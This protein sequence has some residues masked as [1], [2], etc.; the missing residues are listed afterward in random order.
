MRILLIH[1]EEIWYKTHKPAVKN[2]PD[3]PGEYH[4]TNAVVAYVSIEKGD[5]DEVVKNAAEEIYRY[6]TDTVK[7]DSIILYPYAHLSSTLER[8]SRAHSLLVKLELELKKKWSKKLHRAPFGWYKEFKLHAKGHPLSELSR[9]ITPTTLGVFYRSEGK[10]YALSEAAKNNLVPHCLAKASLRLNKLGREKLDLFGVVGW[11]KWLAY[12]MVNR[13]LK[14]ITS[15]YGLAE[16]FIGGPFIDPNNIDRLER[17]AELYRT[18]FTSKSNTLVGSPTPSSVYKF[19]GDMREFLAEVNSGFEKHV[20]TLKLCGDEPCL[21]IG[22]EGELILY[23]NGDGCLPLGIVKGSESIIGPLGNLLVSIIDIESRRAEEGD[24]IPS[25]PVWMHPITVYII[26]V[27]EVGDYVNTLA[28]ELAA[29]GAGVV[30][31]TSMK[32][33]GGRVRNAGKHWVPYTL[34]I[35]KREVETGTVTV[36]RRWKPGSQEAVSL[37]EFVSEVRGVLA[38]YGMNGFIRHLS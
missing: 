34:T 27:G 33:V 11:S 21:D 35:G 36:R 6:A 1:A 26:P 32:G 24:H 18:A 22:V 38:A 31:D 12:E 3:P 25:I 8:P 20:I 17:V 14:R 4:D 2:P 15:R 7:S 19:I 13:L 9:T 37:S 10:Q 29:V 28:K 16:H 5:N 30:V 23:R